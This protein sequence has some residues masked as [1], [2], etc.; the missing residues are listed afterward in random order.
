MKNKLAWLKMQKLGIHI[1]PLGLYD[2]TKFW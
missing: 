1:S 2:K